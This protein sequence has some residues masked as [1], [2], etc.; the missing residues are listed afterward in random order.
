MGVGVSISHGHGHMVPKKHACNLDWPL[1][2]D[3][4]SSYATCI[5]ILLA[6]IFTPVF[7]AICYHSSDIKF[8]K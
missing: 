7:L 4:N 6:P 8:K 1:K 5:L 3:T 2:K